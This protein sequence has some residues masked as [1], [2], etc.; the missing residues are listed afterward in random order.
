MI[1]LVV[2][3]RDEPWK[4]KRDD[5][6]MLLVLLKDGDLNVLA[7]GFEGRETIGGEGSL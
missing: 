5:Q 2:F 3:E 1:T 4:C 6:G 7:Q